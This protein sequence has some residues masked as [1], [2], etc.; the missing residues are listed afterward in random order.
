MAAYHFTA[1]VVSRGKGQSAVAKAA[2]NARARLVDRRTGEAKDFS[3][4]KDEVL[5]S[6]I[7]APRDAPE[8]AHDREQLWNRVEAA[9]DR[10]NRKASVAQL[11]REVEI[12]LPHEL[13][14]Q[15][16]EW[17]VKD[18]VRENFQ[19]QGMVTDVNIHAP[20]AHG[21]QRNYHA[22]ILL[23]MRRIDGNEFSADKELAWNKRDQ[24]AHWKEDLAIKGANMLE[25]AGFEEEA[26]RFRWGYLTLPQQRQKALERGDREF[27]DACDREPT[28]HRGPTVDA[29]EKNGIVTE[30]GEEWRAT[31]QRNTELDELVAELA[32]LENEIHAAE[33]DAYLDATDRD[34]AAWDNKL[35]EAAVEKEKANP[36]FAEYE[37]APDEPSRAP[38]T[39]ELAVLENDIRAAE[40][41][42]YLD[43]ADRDRAAWD[44]KLYDAAVEKEKADPQ[45]AECERASDEPS[46][47][48]SVAE[49]AVLE[50]Q[51][52][53]IETDAYL[54]AADRGQAAWDNKLYDAAVEK[55]NANPQFA[56]RERASDKPS[57]APSADSNLE[58]IV[59]GAEAVIEKVFD[60][61]ERGVEM[62]LEAVATSFESL[63]DAG[64]ARPVKTKPIAREEPDEKLD[65]RRYILD[66]GYR[67][68][69]AEQDIKDKDRQ[70]RERENA[71]RQNERQW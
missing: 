50:N 46:R 31:R 25:R 26:Q 24:L 65:F 2:Y 33:I 45:F 4:R 20:S 5:F 69:V 13:T 44:N 35:Y 11:A 27:A 3:R 40:I 23:T 51:I 49:L 41:D 68:Q 63:F 15:Q 28:K 6:G 48:P 62:T 32:A 12:A 17:L 7:F 9:E 22:H 34:R 16:R 60:I 18:Y 54:D 61:A 67:R 47:A 19:R 38:S 70:R 58:T 66:Q 1:K 71:D 57:R 30:R 29:M 10:F 37:R 52:R 43:A 14:D 21:D 8:W 56:E 53:A 36:Q 64:P 59:F 39:A 42:T 55:E